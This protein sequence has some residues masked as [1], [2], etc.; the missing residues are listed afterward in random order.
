MAGKSLCKIATCDKRVFGHG[1]CY[2]HYYRWYKHGDPLG[3]GTGKGEPMRYLRDKVIPYSGL[4][5]LLWPYGKGSNGYGMLYV[6]G[7]KQLVHRLVCEAAHGA[8]ATADLQAAHGCGNGHLG[9]VTPAHLSWKSTADNH[10]D[11]I[12]HG[13]M[14]RGE[15]QWMAKLTQADVRAIRSLRGKMTQKAI[16]DQFGVTF[17]NVSA[18]HR[19][20]SWA[21]LA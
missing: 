12:E 17:S 20:K 15:R 4:D 18:I 21:W 1:W 13:T 8:P 9:C 10:A 7:R 6:D 11:K 2:A 16:A 3:G 14:L 19:G 5:C